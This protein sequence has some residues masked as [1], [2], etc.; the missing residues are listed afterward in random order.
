M[1]AIL[2]QDTCTGCTLCTQTCSE[3]FEMEGDKAVVKADPV[4]E[5]YQDSC[6]D[7][8]QGCPVDAITIEE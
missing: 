5:E 7:A 8:A 2:D 6:R 3:V 1:K 4:P